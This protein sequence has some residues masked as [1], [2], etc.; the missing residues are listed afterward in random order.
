MYY[1]RVNRGLSFT[2]PGL[3]AVGLLLLIG[4]IAVGTGI[5]GLYVFLSV[6][7][8]GYVISGLISEKAMKSTRI[9]ALGSAVADAGAAFPVTITVENTSSWFAV[10]EMDTVV[11]L[12][13]PRFKLIAEPLPAPLT[14]RAACLAARRLTTISGDCR[15]LPRGVHETVTAVLKTKFPF[16][17]LEKFKVVKVPARLVIGPAVDD[18]Y[19]SEV[20]SRLT[21]ILA[22]LDQDREFF[23]HRNYQTRDSRRDVDWRKSAAKAP[24]DWVIKQYKARGQD[25]SVRIEAPWAAIARAPDG[26]A[27]ERRLSRLRTLMRGLSEAGKAFTLDFGG[28]LEVHGHD[29]GIESLAGAP[30]YVER[31]RGPRVGGTGTRDMAPAAAAFV[32][33]FDGETVVWPGGA[34]A[35]EGSC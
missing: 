34:G 28:G 25:A 20:R 9:A 4:M 5:N 8:G 12:G 17:I 7:M 27:Y 29:A 1:K 10:Y 14:T 35:R 16:G 32:L 13:E 6:G 24:R 18:A 3:Y 33:T 22:A 19:L 2:K 31:D 15:G 30:A 26:P 11:L 21:A 23:S